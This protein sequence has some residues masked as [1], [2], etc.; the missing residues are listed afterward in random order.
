MSDTD[1][2]DKIHADADGDLLGVFANRERTLLLALR[3]GSPATVIA[4]DPATQT[5]SLTVDTLAVASTDLP[6]DVPDPPERLDRV[7]VVFTRAM[8]GLA[9]DTIPVLP[10]DTGMIFCMDR[11]I[12]Q[13]RRLGVPTDPIDGRTHSHADAV[14]M[15]GLHADTDP[16]IPP[17][18]LAARV[19]EAPLIMLGVGA[20][21]PAVLG[22][23]F[24]AAL[25]AYTSGMI[26]AANTWA[27]LAPGAP[28]FAT[29]VTTL[30]TALAAALAAML[31]TKVLVQ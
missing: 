15:P 17:T 20:T 7:P 26:T 4:Y 11:A 24:A 13:W 30:N 29:A 27:G 14:F 25:A 9:Y 23:A 8:G 18:S 1:R 16:I 31:S 6:V 28:A 10:G 12:D 3:T 5:A 22:T 2:R 19:I 21:Q